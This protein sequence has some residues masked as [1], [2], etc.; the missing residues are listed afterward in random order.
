MFPIINFLIH[1]LLIFIWFPVELNYAF[2]LSL[3]IILGSWDVNS[4]FTV[5]KGEIEIK[6][7]PNHFIFNEG[8]FHFLWQ[9]RT[10]VS[11]RRNW[12]ITNM[13]FNS[14]MLT[15]WT[16]LPIARHFSALCG[17]SCIE[18]L[19]LLWHA[20]SIASR[21]S[22]WINGVEITPSGTRELCN[23]TLLPICFSSRMFIR[24]KTRAENYSPGLMA[25]TRSVVVWTAFILR[26]RGDHKC[27]TTRVFLLRIQTTIWFLSAYN[28]GIQ[29]PEGKASGNLT[30]GCWNQK[31]SA[32]P[33]KISG[34][35]G[36]QKSLYSLIRGF[37][38]MQ[39]NSNLKKLP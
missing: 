33:W 24:W 30:R 8:N 17:V 3:I 28:W 5:Y 39:A 25:H 1:M 29:I 6:I 38:G 14:S 12:N 27:V 36:N 9:V 18:M 7:I 19:T 37:G 31:N 23:Y 2:H 15:C 26:R 20:I 10:A 13:C 16:N 32:L 11:S 4:L 35:N 22:F 21:I 34:L